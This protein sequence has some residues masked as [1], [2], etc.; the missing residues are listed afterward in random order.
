M[1]IDP[2]KLEGTREGK[3]FSLRAR[4]LR[5]LNLFNSRP[6]QVLDRSDIL[7]QIWGICYEGT[8]RTL[9]QHISQLRKRIERDP[10]NPEIIQ[11][12]HGV[13]YRYDK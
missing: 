10:Q 12:V 11:T 13:G 2:Q 8:T 6:D 4:E 7:D 3:T 5:L 9:D 1:Q